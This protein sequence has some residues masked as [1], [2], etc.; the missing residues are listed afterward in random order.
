MNSRAKSPPIFQPN[1]QRAAEKRGLVSTLIMPSASCSERVILGARVGIPKDSL[2]D[3]GIAVKPEREAA[4][5]RAAATLT[6]FTS[7]TGRERAGAARPLLIGDP[8][9]S[10]SCNLKPVGSRSL[11]EATPVRYDG[12]GSSR[13][14]RTLQG[15]A[16]TLLCQSSRH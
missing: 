11:Y 5:P 4:A 13:W 15:K 12:P 14:L 9:S 8:P 3:R 1:R 6:L 10:L 2:G 16:G 7:M